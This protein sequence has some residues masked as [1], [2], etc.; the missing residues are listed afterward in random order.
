MDL[1][2]VKEDKRS[3]ILIENKDERFGGFS[4]PHCIQHQV[5]FAND[6]VPA[7]V[8]YFGGPKSH[9]ERFYAVQELG[10]LLILLFQSPFAHRRKFG[11]DQNIPAHL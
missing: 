9:L 1:I 4:F 11:N 8:V 2:S 5:W 6:F 7:Y 3:L 10:N